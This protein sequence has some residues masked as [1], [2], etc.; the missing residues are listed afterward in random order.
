[1]KKHFA[2]FKWYKRGNR[3]SAIGKLNAIDKKNIKLIK[4]LEKKR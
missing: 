2:R 1:M 4:R 3:K